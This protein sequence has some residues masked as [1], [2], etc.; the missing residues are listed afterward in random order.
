MADE[1]QLAI[2]VEDGVQR[3]NAWLV[4]NP[5]VLTDLSGADLQ[6]FYLVAANFRGINLQDAVLKG[7]RLE[8]ANLT[9]ANLAGV[10]FS[11]ANLTKAKLSKARLEGA[12][13]T[14][15][16]LSGVDLADANLPN[17]I[18]TDA[19]FMNAALTGA[20]FRGATLERASFVEAKID[21]RTVGLGHLL[22]G[23]RAQM[24]DVQ[25]EAIPEDTPQEPTEPPPDKMDNLTVGYAKRI[26]GPAHWAL[27]SLVIPNELTDEHRDLFNR[28]INTV[29]ELQGKLADIEDE[30][31]RLADE[32][33]TLGNSMGQA[34]PLWKKAFEEFVVKYAGGLGVQAARGTAFAAGFIAG[35][36][37]NTLS[38]GETGL[39]I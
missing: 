29:A 20:N 12:N 1:E 3:W 10:D 35:T 11:S 21:H 32:N 38:P 27:Q 13:L 28:L 5:R 30:N 37:Y 33:E 39:S 2:I 19:N 9:A 23:Q 14:K 25:V 4:E 26:V 36:L 24:K 8:G 22:A 15:A 31:R 6:G 7:A 17:T 16:N 34:L 18:L